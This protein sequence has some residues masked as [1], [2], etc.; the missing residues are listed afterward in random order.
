MA[1]HTKFM[2][3]FKSA[4]LKMEVKVKAVKSGKTMNQYIL[5]CVEYP[6]YVIENQNGSTETVV[7]ISG[8]IKQ[9]EPQLKCKHEY[10]VIGTGEVCSKCG[11]MESR[12]IKKDCKHEKLTVNANKWSCVDCGKDLEK[13]KEEESI[14]VQCVH[15]ENLIEDCKCIKEALDKVVA[16]KTKEEEPFFALVPR[17]I[18]DEVEALIKPKK[19]KPKKEKIYLNGKELTAKEVKLMGYPMDLNKLKKPKGLQSSKK[20]FTKK[21]QCLNPKVHNKSCPKF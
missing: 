7:P 11:H 12:I 2:L 17:E 5:D 14:K 21:C 19:T 8:K 9:L 16:K 18:A 1:K 10:N 20:G 6:I 3:N 4:E 15:C 13:P